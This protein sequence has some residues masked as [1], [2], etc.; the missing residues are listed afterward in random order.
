MVKGG[1]GERAPP[2]HQAG[3]RPKKNRL[4]RGG[5]DQAM[6]NFQTSAMTIPLG[7]RRPVSLK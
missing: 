1:Q 7:M 6:E 5:C 2:G 4:E 3:S